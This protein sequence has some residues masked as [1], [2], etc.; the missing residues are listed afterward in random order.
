MKIL[1]A[2]DSNSFRLTAASILKESGKAE[3]IFTAPDGKSAL[4]KTKLYEPD[5][6]FLD[7]EMPEL[8]GMETL[9]ELKK[10]HPQ[11]GVIMCSALTARGA[12][13]TVEALELGAFD[14]ITKPAANQG[15][16]Q[17]TLDELRENILL[18]LDAFH[19]LHS[20]RDAVRREKSRTVEKDFPVAASPPPLDKT[21]QSAPEK[22]GQCVAVAVSTGGPEA[23]LALLTD[24]PKNFNVPVFIVQHMPS[25]FTKALA[26]NLSSKTGHDIVEGRDGEIVRKGKIYIAPGGR[27]MLVKSAEG[28]KVIRV[29]DD[30]PRKFCRPSADLMFRSVA[31]SY[32]K[33]AVGVVM[34]GMGDDG[35]E[36][37]GHIRAAGG[38]TI[39]QDQES[40]LIYGMPRAAVEAGV[41][42]HVSNLRFLAQSILRATV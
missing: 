39:A 9:K 35:T 30:P 11:T 32:G 40:S 33:E 18:R 12:D 24:L 42:D 5:L 36:G 22:R 13:I 14:F 2:D 28:Q 41:I 1:I 16:F 15:D 4:R 25:H 26:D 21:L 17:E 3:A 8:D 10:H 7:V 27:H 31:R 29:T 19:R 38:Y 20:V 6:V 37:L 34:T 23:L